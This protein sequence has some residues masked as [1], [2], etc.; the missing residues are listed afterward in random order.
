VADDIER[1]RQLLDV[2]RRLRSPQGCPWDRE[3]THASL[4]ATML[5]EAYEVLE[6]ID[7][8]SM[9]KLREELGDVLLQVLMQ[10][11]IADEAGDFTLGD[12]ADAVREKLV[13]RHPHVFGS[14]VVSGADEVVRNWEALKAV[15]YGRESALDGVQRSLPA[16]QWAWSLQRRAANVGF[17]WPDVDGALDKVREEL[18][19]VREAPTVEAREAEFGDLLFTLVN[20]ARKLGM[21]PED[22]LRGATGR[23]EARFRM[24][25][26]RATAEG[27]DLKD[28]PIEELDQYW[29]A[30][31]RNR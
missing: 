16:L 3:Q 1:I 18:E 5:E 15:E 24:M 7:E 4:R 27:R 25:E 28:L 17:D 10:S 22:A 12:V 11:E 8:Q 30:A 13:R 23:F 26:Q 21:N 19:E 31:K 29:E 14:T 20:V 9:P 2:V 6:A